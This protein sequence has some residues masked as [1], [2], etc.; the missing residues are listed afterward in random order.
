MNSHS[1]KKK[2]SKTR[3]ANFTFEADELI[4]E[5][6]SLSDT[7]ES[8]EEENSSD[9]SYESDFIDDTPIGYSQRDIDFYL[10]NKDKPLYIKVNLPARVAEDLEKI[11]SDMSSRGKGK[12]TVSTSAK[13]APP[14]PVTKAAEAA[15]RRYI[16]SNRHREEEPEEE[17]PSPPPSPVKKKGGKQTAKRQVEVVADPDEPEEE[18]DP[19]DETPSPPPPKKKKTQWQVDSPIADSAISSNVTVRSKKKTK[20]TAAEKVVEANEEEEESGE[21]S[22]GSVTEVATKTQPPPQ[23]RASSPPNRGNK[24]PRDEALLNESDDWLL[25]HARQVEED[26]ANTVE[27]EDLQTKVFLCGICNCPCHVSKAEKDDRVFIVC[28][29]HCNFEY[30]QDFN[31]SIQIHKLARETLSK[32]F[33][34]Q[35]G[36]QLPRCPAHHKVGTLCAPK[37]SSQQCTAIVG[38]LFFACV[39]K[40]E[41]GG[42]CHESDG[43]RWV[44]CASVDDELPPAKY[45]SR[46]KGL[47][48]L[49]KM[50][51]KIKAEK[52]EEAVN[53]VAAAAKQIDIDFAHC[54]GKFAYRANKS[55]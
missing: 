39:A 51:I 29:G 1:Q 46:K 5:P 18:L 19:E 36:G 17:P 9:D 52:N 20:P 26:L 3:K 42:P 15:H 8:A 40:K 50:N 16:A 48:K 53:L 21:E 34:P 23:P 2:T 22:D 27:P 45:E 7:D 25:A 38:K 10:R 43:S 14:S 28:K 44:V 13:P 49:Y 4:L 55:S 32:R 30:C 37:T 31:D 12:K 33:R 54:V 35:K 6:E 41:E 11:T 47:E 24:K